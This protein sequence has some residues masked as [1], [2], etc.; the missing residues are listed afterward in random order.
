MS[1]KIISVSRRSDV[2]AW[3]AD[4]FLQGLKMGEITYRVSPKHMPAKVSLKKEY[5]ECFVFWS[6]SYAGFMDRLDELDSY[7]I[8][9]YMHFTINNYPK[10]F[11][12]CVPPAKDMIKTFMA[13]SRRYGKDRI[14][15]RYDPIFFTHEIGIKEHTKNFEELLDQLA[16]YTDS[17]YISI[18][19]VYEKLLKKLIVQQRFDFDTLNEPAPILNM[20][21]LMQKMCEGKKVQLFTCAEDALEVIPGIRKG[22][23]ISAELVGRLSKS[24]NKFSLAPTRQACGCAKAI[25]IGTYNTCKHG[26][27][28]CYANAK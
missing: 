27:I 16:D 9:F 8:P 26:C 3:N 6:K 17:C 19:D 12:P 18:I 2:P 11:E 5:V 28:Y 23:C 4:W 14:I 21:G 25:D 13:L 20:T 15:W 10:P 22:A 24:D 1:K 7:G